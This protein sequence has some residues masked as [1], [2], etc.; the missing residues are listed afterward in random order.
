MLHVDT[1]HTLLLSRERDKKSMEPVY[2]IW[3]SLCTFLVSAVF[4]PN[5][6]LLI[7]NVNNE[8][9]QCT[10]N[11]SWEYVSFIIYIERKS[12]CHEKLVTETFSAF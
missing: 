5:T 10:Q 12:E 4:H 3:Y 6:L 8:V 7:C 11:V 9:C 2:I 1:K